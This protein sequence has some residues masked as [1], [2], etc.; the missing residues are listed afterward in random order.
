APEF[1]LQVCPMPG[2][3]ATACPSV[4]IHFAVRKSPFVECFVLYWA[5]I[6]VE[7]GVGRGPKH[8]TKACRGARA[9]ARGGRMVKKLMRLHTCSISAVPR[10]V[11]D[12]EVGLHALRLG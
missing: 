9:A 7:K 3:A 12:T 1:L 8:C 6:C 2:C 10:A 11:H 5:Y 4:P